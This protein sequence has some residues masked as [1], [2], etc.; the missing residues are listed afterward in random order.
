[1]GLGSMVCCLRGRKCVREY[2]DGVFMPENF[3]I[4]SKSYTHHGDDTRPRCS[5]LF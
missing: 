4:F 2:G 3:S 1:M 5:V